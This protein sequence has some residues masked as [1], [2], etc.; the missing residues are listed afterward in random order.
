MMIRLIY[1]TLFLLIL[2]ACQP[3][4]EPTPTT[5]P[6]PSPGS[7]EVP[8]IPTLEAGVSGTPSSPAGE[9]PPVP[10]ITSDAPTSA[11]PASE[12]PK[13][14]QPSPSQHHDYPLTLYHI[15]AQFDYD[16]NF[17][18]V[19]QT[20]TYTNT[21]GLSIADLLLVVEANR[22]F[23]AFR[24][25][26]L[27]W[28]SGD[29]IET[30]Q[31]EFHRLHIPLAE[32]LQPGQAVV[33]HISYDLNLPEIPSPSAVDR[34][35]PFGYSARQTNLV[36]WYPFFPPYFPETG[37]A[38]HD[39]WFF[40]EHQVYD[41]A[42][43]EVEIQM[44]GVRQNVTLAASAPAEI[45]G[46]TYRYTMEAARSFALS[47]SN[48]YTIF[49]QQ[50]GDVT[51]YSYAFPFDTK[52]GERA[53]Q[54]T[55][56]ALE[57]YS[58]LFGPYPHLSLSV[59]EADFLDGMEYDGLFFLSRGFYALFDGTPLGY[60]TAIAVHETA[61][62]W[63]YGMVGNNQA[64]EPWLDEALCTYSEL[65]YYEN[66]YPDLVDGW[67]EFRVNYQQPSGLIDGSIY[68]YNGF[69]SYRDATYLR[70][71]QFLHEL[72]NLMGDQA[73]FSFLQHYISRSRM[74]PF[75]M[76]AS[77]DFFLILGEHTS[78]DITSLMEE[79]FRDLE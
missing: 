57:L 41:L 11:A 55:A 9:A 69:V 8:L 12:A 44:T 35:L 73:F 76:A 33:L 21:S 47:A 14:E 10:T 50:V 63:W 15:S 40:G 25:K 6:S 78:A 48:M 51:V 7:Q 23:G 30:Y 22:R 28:E 24:L 29:P 43:Y 52:G 59:V 18:S 56:A 74:K 17:L 3:Q 58:R 31:L 26:S 60:L 4:V 53:L 68:D 61:H 64:L 20:I 13:T 2:A 54:D 75:G 39:P 42:D 1:I 37:W 77:G 5:S 32:P 67:W 46:R 66:L 79:Y 38:V 71:A 49:S 72:R 27:S 45:D 16:W 62:Q 70:G 34:P 36:D 65:L 19:D